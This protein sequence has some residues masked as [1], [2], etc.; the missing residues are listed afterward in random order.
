[1]LEGLLVTVSHLNYD[2]TMIFHKFTSL[3]KSENCIS[4]NRVSGNW[5]SGNWVSGN[6]VS[7]NC[8]SE[9]HVSKIRIM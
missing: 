6:L 9:N 7:N 4:G 1:M 8:V 3:M 2:S 5:V